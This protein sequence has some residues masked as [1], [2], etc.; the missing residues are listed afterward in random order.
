MKLYYLNGENAGQTYELPCGN[1]SIGRETDNVL[2]LSVGGVSRYH[3]RIEYENGTWYITDLGS[4]NGTTLND[5]QVQGRQP[6]KNGDRIILGDQTFTVKDD[7]PRAEDVQ[8]QESP[9]FKINIPGISGEND[10]AEKP[11]A[12][13]EKTIVMPSADSA[14]DKQT[15]TIPNPSLSKPE[16]ADSTP[17]PAP[18]P[19][20]SPEHYMETLMNQKFFKSEAENDTP[21]YDRQPGKSK[22][23]T[24]RGN[25][26][27]AAVLLLLLIIGGGVIL[28]MNDDTAKQNSSSLQS[29]QKKTITQNP[30]FFSCERMITDEQ[31]QTIFKFKVR[32]E[33]LDG[34][35]N[36][37]V[38]LSDLSSDERDRQFKKTFQEIPQDMV[39]SLQKDLSKTGFFEIQDPAPGTLTPEK[40]KYFNHLVAGYA[41]KLKD[42]TLYEGDYSQEFDDAFKCIEDFL[43]VLGLPKIMSTKEDIL[44][45]AEAN[46]IE[47]DNNFEKY[48]S[49]DKPTSVIWEAIQNYERAEILYGQFEKKPE[50]YERIKTRLADLRKTYKQL[51]NEGRSDVNLYMGKRDYAGVIKTCKRMMKI[52]PETSKEYQEFRDKKLEAEVILKKKRERK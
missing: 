33:K 22:S 12:E 15:E 51:D 29:N 4:T 9:V 40:R 23:S 19:P 14:G 28:K 16:S 2:R 38:M 31:K 5:R 44:Q 43:E 47:G 27:F 52:F 34:K 48:Q 37:D 50:S 45:L 30:F 39:D 13:I 24:L 11:V 25:L 46:T 36:V 41:E 21:T 1:T 17:P 26:I 49:Q 20:K 42:I 3:A 18:I 10:S 6:L 35:F 8:K 7:A 32:G